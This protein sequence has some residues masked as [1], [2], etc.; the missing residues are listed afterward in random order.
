[1]AL[2]YKRQDYHKQQVEQM[3]DEKLSQSLN[4]T[5]G[6]FREVNEFIQG[7][8]NEFKDYIHST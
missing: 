2:T 6:S 5:R 3:I 1:L 8:H 4:I 7:F